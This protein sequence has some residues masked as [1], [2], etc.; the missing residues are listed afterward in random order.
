M[1]LVD[2]GS[3]KQCHDLFGHLNKTELFLLWQV[4]KTYCITEAVLNHWIIIYGQALQNE[5][6]L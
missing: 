5:T 4:E 1:V 3:L 2:S 6:Q